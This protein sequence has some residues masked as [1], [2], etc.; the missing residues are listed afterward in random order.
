MFRGRKDALEL[1]QVQ[2][3]LGS[4][5]HLLATE[6]MLDVESATTVSNDMEGGRPSF[7][8]RLELTSYGPTRE[9][10]VSRNQLG[11]NIVIPVEERELSSVLKLTGRRILLTQPAPAGSTRVEVL[12]AEVLSL[13]NELQQARSRLEMLQSNYLTLVE[14][15]R[16]IT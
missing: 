8:V 1:S 3:T 12:E 4:N 9:Y 7:L 5:V 11:T 10:A 14:E 2:E 6:R 13:Q 16:K 15:S